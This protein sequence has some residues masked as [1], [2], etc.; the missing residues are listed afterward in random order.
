MIG[1]LIHEGQKC[2]YTMEE[3]DLCGKKISFFGDP[4]VFI[5]LT[6]EDMDEHCLYE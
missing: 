5:P 4:D 6:E 1:L 3:A 2:I